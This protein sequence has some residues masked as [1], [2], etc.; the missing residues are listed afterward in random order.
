MTTCIRLYSKSDSEGDFHLDAIQRRLQAHSPDIQIKEESCFYVVV[1]NVHLDALIERSDDLKKLLSHNVFH[2]DVKPESSFKEGEGEVVEVGPRLTFTTPFST[3]AVS[4][5]QAA[6]FKGIIRLEKSRRYQLIGASSEALEH[7]DFLQE[8]G[9]KMTEQLYYTTPSFVNESPQREDYFFVDV[10]GKDGAENLEKVNQEL[11]LSLDDSDKEYYLNMYRK[12]GRN[13]TDV[14]LFDLAQSNSEHS[15]HWFFKGNLVVDGVQ[16][17]NHLFKTIQSTQDHSNPNNVIAFCDNSSAIKGFESPSI[18]PS[19]TTESSALK[20]E[21]RTKHIIYTAETHN[22]PTGV[23]PF[24]GAATGT[25]GRLRDV[26]ATGQG[27]HEVAGVVGYSFGNL[28]LEDFEQPWEEDYHSYPINLAHPQKVLLDASNGASDYGNKFGEPVIA[29]FSRSFGQLVELA[30]GEKER[31][32]YI[33]PI[34]FSGGIGLMDSAHS[35]KAECEKGQLIAKIGGP[36][37]RIG[38]GGGAASSVMVQGDR[39]AELDYGAVQRGDPEMEQK[40]HRVIRA[41]VEMNQNNPILSIH[42]QGAGGNGNVLKEIVEGKQGGAIIYSDKFLL[43]DPTIS[44]RELWGAEYQ[45]NDAIL[46]NKDRQEELQR[47]GKR[48]RCP[49]QIVGEVTGDNQVVLKDFENND[50]H[51][52][53]INLHELA[54]RDPKTFHLDSKEFVHKPLEIP[55]DLSVSKAL[56]LVLRLPSVSSKR[57]L[58]NKVDRSVTGLIAQQ[59]CVGPLQLP[60][61]DCGVTAASY[62][63]TVGS[64]VG[65]GEQPIRGL[66]DPGAGARCSVAESLT[67]LV[68]TPI[69]CLEDVKCSGNWMWPARLEGEGQRLVA[70]C[71]GMCGFMKAI[72]VAIDGGKDSLSMAAKVG[73]D[74]VKS[75]GTLVISSYAPCTDITKVVGPDLK[76]AGEGTHL[77]LVHMNS[78]Q[79]NHR[80]GGSA[81]AQTL[82]QIGTES[83]DIGDPKY[84]KKCFNAIQNLVNEKLILAGH[85]ISDGGLLTTVLEMAFAGNCG[86]ELDFNFTSKNFIEELFNEEVGVVFEVDEQNLAAVSEQLKKSEISF[87]NIGKALPVYGSDAHVT[88]AVKGEKILKEKLQTLYEIFEEVSDKMELLQTNPKCVEQQKEWRKQIKNPEYKLTFGYGQNLRET[89]KNK[90]KVAIIREEGSNGDREMAAAFI[91]AGFE[92]VDVTM[93]DLLQHTVSLAQFKGIAFV[94]GFSYADVLGSAKGWAASIQM[95]KDL[96]IEFEEFRRRK[97]TF[98]FGVC[99]GCQLMALLG[100]I[101]DVE[102]NNAET[103]VFLDRNDCGRFQSSF[104]RVRI[105]KSKAIMLKGMEGSVLGVWSSHGEGKFTYRTAETLKKLESQGLIGLRY[106]DEANNTTTIYPANP[107]GSEAGVAGVC[108]ADGRH[109]S[110]MP[111]PDRAFLSWQWPNYPDGW[112]RKAGN[113]SPWIRIFE[114]A[115]EWV[116]SQQ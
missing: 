49:I 107:N 3:N 112:A 60:L 43:G 70:A 68:F 113:V 26:Q 53:D 77:I 116:Q 69:T 100:W 45:E 18:L 89:A 52:V 46:L 5:L 39:T 84:F 79:H 62:F 76:V 4:A 6:G 101:G 74:V 106:V 22:F 30:N 42:D 24:P 23:C 75:P 72:G 34:L 11:G 35:K 19:N 54:E 29:G 7:V 71:D 63:D 44:I 105:E 56:G 86:L 47:I 80:M 97:D 82:K 40:V 87:D 111:H 61:A 93:T 13:P 37:Y 17:E 66:V 51:P 83:P 16:R 90:P 15:R 94:G 73:H 99:N 88:I 81:L 109:F 57:F 27:A 48:E 14:E 55:E 28:H 2:Q 10:L 110:L 114:N 8:F 9:D 85:D 91:M 31:I 92:A 50:Q 67:N 41:C 98:S 12:L 96:A 65:L 102:E 1:E 32:E 25:G 33:K 20:V 58:T 21:N 78:K 38:L 108:S 64:V 95:H 115:Y 104:S 59:Q 36:V 103:Q